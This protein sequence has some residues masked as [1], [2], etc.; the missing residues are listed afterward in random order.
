MRLR[1]ATPL[2]VAIVDCLPLAKQHRDTCVVHVDLCPGRCLRLKSL[3]FVPLGSSQRTEVLCHRDPGPEGPVHSCAHL[4][5][6]PRLGK[7][8]AV[9]T[10]GGVCRVS[11][12][13]RNT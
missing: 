12:I 7:D 13:S 6:P 8:V 10:G 11:R 4:G 5:S 2:V 1:L 3:C 9:A